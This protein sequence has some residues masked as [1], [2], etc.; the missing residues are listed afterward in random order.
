MISRTLPFVSGNKISFGDSLKNFP[1]YPKCFPNFLHRFRNSHLNAFLDSFLESFRGFWHIYPHYIQNF[2]NDA[3]GVSFCPWFLTKVPRGICLRDLSKIFLS[4]F[5]ELISARYHS[6]FCFRNTLRNCS[7][8]L[9][10]FYRS[11]S[12]NSSRNFTQKSFRDFM[13]RCSRNRSWQFS[14]YF[15]CS[16]L[17]NIFERILRLPKILGFLLKPFND[18][19]MIFSDYVPG[20]LK[21][22]RLS[23][24]NIIETVG[25]A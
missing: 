5:L 20:F 11:S 9:R 24:S 4:Y 21:L 1:D 19:C 23:Q 25:S 10:D 7:F 18:F 2:T 14:R 6:Q 16:F 8:L 3:T 22:L 12:L 13:Q 15:C 17:C